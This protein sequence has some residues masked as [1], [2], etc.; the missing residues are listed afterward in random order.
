MDVGTV[1]AWVQITFWALAGIAWLFKW[2]YRGARLHPVLWRFLSSNR[3]LGVLI[4]LGAVFSAW[5]LWHQMDWHWGRREMIV[6]LSAMI[7]G[8]NSTLKIISDQ[9]FSDDMVP[10]DGYAY[11]DVTLVNSCFTYDGGP[12]ILEN[13]KLQDHWY[14]CVKNPDL[15]NYNQLMRTLG[16]F[17][18]NLKWKTHTVLEPRDQK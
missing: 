14:I 16:M 9:T 11:R 18:P 5:T 3:L 4:L 15:N 12:F 2:K 17:R 7:P 1:V 13:V 6:N 8:Q 10:L